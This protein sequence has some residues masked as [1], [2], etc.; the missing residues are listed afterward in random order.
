M[1]LGF[2]PLPNLQIS[3]RTTKEIISINTPEKAAILIP[4][5]KSEDID[6]E[7]VRDFLEANQ[8]KFDSKNSNYSTYFRKL[9]CLYD[10]LT[11]GWEN[12]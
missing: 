5:Q 10:F 7:A 3:D 2:V 11:Y 6:L 9:A 4:H 8:D 12:I 1:M